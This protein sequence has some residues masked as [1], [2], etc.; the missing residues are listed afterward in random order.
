[1]RI[2]RVFIKSKKDILLALLLL[3]F[4]LHYLIKPFLGFYGNGF[5]LKMFDRV[6]YLEF[7]SVL[8]V[9]ENLKN[10]GQLT[11]YST[12]GSLGY[13]E[14]GNVNELFEKRFSSLGYDIQD[15]CELKKVSIE[16]DDI[17]LFFDSD[18]YILFV[19][20]GDKVVRK[21]QNKLC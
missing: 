5:N 20:I 15:L 14:V 4:I 8:D 13:I 9:D 16:S 2:K 17:S 21:F 19:R 6:V 12:D 1:M 11:I 10:D 3:F 18:E 7:S